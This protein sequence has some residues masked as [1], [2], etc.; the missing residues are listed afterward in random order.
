MPSLLAH[1]HPDIAFLDVESS[2][3]EPGS[4]PVEVGVCG[5]GLSPRSW[6]VLP[7]P[8]WPASA[9]SEEAEALHGISRE[10]LGR[11]GLP[12]L[13]VADE[14]DRHLLGL[15]VHSDAVG[16]DGEWLDVLY[17]AAGRVRPFR[18]L[19]EAQAYARLSPPD[20]AGV[21]DLLL[22]W[23]RAN[24]ACDVAYPHIH[25]AGADAL[26]MAAVF[27]MTTDPAFAAET[28]DRIASEGGSG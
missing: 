5:D 24:Q 20:E 23:R 12:A 17:R 13:Q 18:L 2:G 14:L 19:D 11:E 22:R 26:R 3:L 10:T 8:E 15:A 25:R 7:H 28:E 16:F 21:Q 9:W 27:R 4:Y 6:L 1:R